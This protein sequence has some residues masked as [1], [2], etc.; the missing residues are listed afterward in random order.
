MINSARE[1]EDGGER[2]SLPGTVRLLV[3]LPHLCTVCIFMSSL[4]SI[5]L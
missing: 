3:G 5:R 1:E 4:V 2:R